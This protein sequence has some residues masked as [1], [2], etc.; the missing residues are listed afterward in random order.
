METLLEE[1][2]PRWS[3]SVQELRAAEYLK[4]RFEKMG[5]EA[6]IQP[7]TFQHA[8][9]EKSVIT[10]KSPAPWQFHAYHLT[11]TG[12][13]QA[14][15]PLAPV[16]LAR[17]EDTTGDGLAGT[18]ALVEAGIIPL[19]EKLDNLAA[20]GAAAAILYNLEALIGTEWVTVEAEIPVVAVFPQDAELLKALLEDE[21]ITVSVTVEA[22]E[23][24]SRNVVAELA[25]AGDEVVIVGAHYDTEPG[26]AGANDNGSGT[27]IVLSLAETLADGQLPFNVRFIL[28]GA[29]E[30]GLI[31]SRH[32]VES[33]SGPDLGRIKAMLNVDAVGTGSRLALLGLQ[34]FTGLALE[35]A[36]GLGVA[37][38]ASPGLPRGSASDHTSFE[39]AG[40]PVLMF[41][42]PDLSRIHT[43]AD[44]TLEFVQPE[45]LDGAAAVARVLLQSPEFA[46]A[47][48]AR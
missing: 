1:L 18:V 43:A 34:E 12:T 6:Q 44:N 3:A 46:E 26:I 10:V 16:G 31:G 39:Y 41:F 8:P 4:E 45:L 23:L 22:V 47:V 29:E 20:A 13:G 48:T 11:G 27:T 38:E 30:M 5:Y 28:F 24:R 42:G 2:G 40:V 19:Q 35:V 21:A 33:L 9:R 25:G 32:Y 36:E 7:F 15:G 37:A 17:S 14:S